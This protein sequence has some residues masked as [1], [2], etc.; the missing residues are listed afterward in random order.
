MGDA[1]FMG[2][3]HINL[4]MFKSAQEKIP[5]FNNIPHTLATVSVFAVSVFVS[6][7]H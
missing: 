1:L 2:C 7:R 5:S 3:P 4:V 6:M